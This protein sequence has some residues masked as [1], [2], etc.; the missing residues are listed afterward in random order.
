MKSLV[1]HMMNMCELAKSRT[2]A[3]LIA[4]I[5]P[6]IS[7]L[8]FADGGTWSLDSAASSAL[9]FQGSAANPDSVN[10]GVARV[11]GNVKLDTNDL[12]NSVFNL[13]IYPADE[14]WGEALS[15]ESTLPAGYVPDATDH[16]LLTFASKRI[17]RMGDG[18][19]EVIGD[20]TLT[21]VER[22]VTL[23]KAYARPVYGDPVVHTETREVRLLFPNLSAALSAG[24]LR[25]V[26]LKEKR[27]LDLSGSAHIGYEDFPGL[28]SAIR[29]T[30]WPVV[31]Q[32]ERCQM[33][34]TVGEGYHGPTCTGTVIAATSRDN[35][36]MPTTVGGEDYSGPICAPPSGNQ[37][38]IVLDLRMVPTSADAATAIHSGTSQLDKY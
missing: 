21:R 22:T 16:T 2:L 7:P 3:I 29:T 34:S 28:L 8:A 19:L 31:V 12:E 33:P 14:Q 15:P 5:L 10:T 1:I 4:V 17:L 9:L 23:T 26:N 6:T 35:C 32:N 27:N 11:T 13:S 37:T 20:L 18:K 38:T 36:H 30:N 24:P 25:R